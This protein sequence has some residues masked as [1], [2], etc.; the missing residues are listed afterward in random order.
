MSDSDAES[1]AAE[2]VGEGELKKLA[3][4]A[5]KERLE[6]VDAVLAAVKRMST[7]DRAANAELVC[8]FVLKKVF[9]D[10][11]IQVRKLSCRCFISNK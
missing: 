6:C 5:W 11:N 8:C 1:R 10:V 2:L 4:S 3:S 7:D 9:G